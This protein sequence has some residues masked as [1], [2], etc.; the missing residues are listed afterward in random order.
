MARNGPSGSSLAARLSDQ[1]QRQSGRPASADD[2][3]FVAWSR[4]TM[5]QM[6]ASD[7]AELERHQRNWNRVKNV[8]TVA[9]AVPFGVAAAPWIGSALGI[10]AGGGGGGAAAAGAGGSTAAGAGTGAAAIG[11]AGAGGA[12]VPATATA[13]GLPWLR[14]SEIGVGAGMNLWGQRQSNRA[15]DRAAQLEAEGQAAYRAA[16]ER[17]H[18]LDEKRFNADEEQRRLDRAA[19]DE[20]RAFT[21]TT[22]ED[23]ERRRGPYRAV[24]QGALYSLAD[25]A[26]IRVPQMGNGRA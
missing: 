9:A 21:R 19:A 3:E 7:R 16:L 12:I 25:I 8:A 26:K 18:A 6:M 11:A 22:F 14:L 20:E 2:P 15:G 17:Q 4:T 24:S 1:W 23:K 13:A 5:P 10:G